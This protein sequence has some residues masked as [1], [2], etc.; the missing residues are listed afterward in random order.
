VGRA[1]DDPFVGHWFFNAEKSKF[2]D[3]VFRIEKSGANRYQ[4]TFTDGNKLTLPADGTTHPNPLGGTASLEQIDGQSLR[5][6]R[7]RGT[8]RIMTI[9]AAVDGNSIRVDQTDTLAAGE[10]RTWTAEWQRIEAGQGVIGGWKLKSGDFKMSDG[11]REMDI[12]PFGSNGLS[13]LYPADKYRLDLSSTVNSTPIRVPMW[14][15]AALTS[16]RASIRKRSGSRGCLMEN[17]GM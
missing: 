5:L 13:F 11:A 3:L 7:K 8:D 6:F 1:A 14:R 12:E 17:R 15:M 4:F 2:G 9:T 10:T 16:V